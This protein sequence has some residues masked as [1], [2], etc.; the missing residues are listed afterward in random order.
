MPLGRSSTTLTG[1]AEGGG[2]LCCVCV[3]VGGVLCVSVGRE[4][5]GW[6]GGGWVGLWSGTLDN[7]APSPFSWR[8]ELYKTTV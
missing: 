2:A 8:F 1:V 3:C 4:W 6:V 5:G 7:I